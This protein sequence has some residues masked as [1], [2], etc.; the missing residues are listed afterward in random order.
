M[1]ALD[2][3]I[4]FA[5]L[6]LV[7][8]AGGTLVS[9]TVVA[10]VATST[11]TLNAQAYALAGLAAT[12]SSAS[13]LIAQA[14][15]SAAYTDGA[16]S[17]ASFAASAFAQAQA[18]AEGT[19]SFLA[20]SS[21][22]KDTSLAAN[23]SA[24][25]FFE[26]SGDPVF[27]ITSTGVV[28]FVGQ[29]IRNTRLADTGTTTTNI[30]LAGVRV[31]NYALQGRATTAVLGSAYYQ[32]RTSIAGSSVT[33]IDLVAIANAAYAFTAQAVVTL[34]GRRVSLVSYGINGTS[35][36]T[37]LT[38]L[39]RLGSLTALGQAQMS[40][41]GGSLSATQM[42]MAGQAVTDFGGVTFASTLPR[43][44]DYVIRE[45]ELR[46]VQRPEENRTALYN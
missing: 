24:F 4:G 30:K 12:A 27:Q 2:Y 10:S 16:T 6:A 44:W 38:N 45:Y 11:E 35:Q 14:K 34:A 28:S 22:I 9:E 37:V 43:A 25:V 13:T 17:T 46:G 15:A 1:L 32:T 42:D 29:S 33:A 40:Y 39:A 36:S 7:E 5:E 31:T 8:V 20:V 19:S 18:F 41:S 3:E 21:A 26:V 23:G